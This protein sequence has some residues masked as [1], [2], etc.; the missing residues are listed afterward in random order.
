MHWM[1]SLE[2]HTGRCVA[3]PRFSYWEV[4]KGM[5]PSSMPL[6][7]ETGSRSPFWALMGTRM[8]LIMA[9]TSA[10]AGWIAAPERFFQLSFTC[11]CFTALMPAS[12]A[13]MF[14]FT[15]FSPLSP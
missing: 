3:M 8:F 4:P 12:T 11:T 15:I 7:A 9:G 5:V 14:M 13:A 2:S 6:K 10:G 1:H